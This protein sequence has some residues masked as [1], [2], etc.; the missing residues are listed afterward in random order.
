MLTQ[1]ISEDYQDIYYQYRETIQEVFYQI[2]TKSDHSI[3][4]R[5]FSML[6]FSMS[7][8]SFFYPDSGEFSEDRLAREVE[9]VSENM[10]ETIWFRKFADQR[11]NLAMP[12]RMIQSMLQGHLQRMRPELK[13]LLESTLQSYADDSD[14]AG[15]L[16]CNAG[17]EN[18]FFQCETMAGVYEQRRDRANRYFGDIIE[19]F[20]ENY[21]THF[22]FSRP[23]TDDPSLF[24]YVQRLILHVMLLK[25][26]LFSHKRIRDIISDCEQ[27]SAPAKAAEQDGAAFIADAIMEIMNAFTVGLTDNESSLLFIR[28]EMENQHMSDLNHAVKFI[29]F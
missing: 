17:A 24:A 15:G 26:C 4:S 16:L 8:G 18:G 23:Y 13:T 5:L 2:V 21:C 1:D 10:Y 27:K 28:Q 7:T 3:Q 14:G 6:C 22:L 9:K 19:W 12:M 11:I 20:I 29:H 25:Y